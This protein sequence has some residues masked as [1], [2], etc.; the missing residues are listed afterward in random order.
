MRWNERTHVP[1]AAVRDFGET[2]HGEEMSENTWLAV[3]LYLPETSSRWGNI[4]LASGDLG[5]FN[6][7]A[8]Y[9]V[10]QCMLM[11]AQLDFFHTTMTVDEAVKPVDDSVESD[12]EEEEL[13]NAADRP[14]GQNGSLFCSDP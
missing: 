14:A 13:D 4:K 1:N 10:W 11:R 2:S 9:E 5:R 7:G 3:A 12:A 8:R 6:R